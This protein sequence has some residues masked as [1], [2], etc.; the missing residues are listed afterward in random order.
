MDANQTHERILQAALK[1]FSQSGYKGASTR[2]IAKEAGVNEVTLFRHFGNK[3]SLFAEMIEN[4]STIP[5]IKAA[6]ENGGKSLENRISRLGVQVIKVLEER[7]DLLSVLLSDGARLKNQGEDLLRGG[8]GRVLEHL[9][10]WF[11]EARKAGEIRKIEPE[12]AARVFMGI[13]FFYMIFQK[14]LPGEKFFP[15]NEKAMVGEFV[16]ILLRGIL[17]LEKRT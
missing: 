15:V 17:P 14:I 13:F 3:Q 8:P 11:R 2:A 4:Y 5:Y 9:I 16:E 10:L 6:R 12:A 7:R 1:V